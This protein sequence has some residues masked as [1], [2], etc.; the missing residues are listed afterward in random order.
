M[1]FSKAD[2]VHA[3]IDM[4]EGEI[5]LA[6]TFCLGLGCAWPV[7][8]F[9][10]KDFLHPTFFNLYPIKFTNSE[11]VFYSGYETL[12]LKIIH[13]EKIDLEEIIVLWK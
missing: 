10:G 2:W 5:A 11:N 4:V 3:E 9:Q 12:E 8:L 7:H 1:S 6:W 13:S